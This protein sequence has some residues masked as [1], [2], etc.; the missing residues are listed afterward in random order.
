MTQKT[1]PAAPAGTSGND[2]FFF[3]TF[4]VA[5]A[6]LIFL[7]G[8]VL[9]AEGIP[10]G[11]QI[12]R[13]LEGGKA[14]YSKLTFHDDVFMSDL[15]HAPR[16]DSRGVT[17]DIPGKTSPGATL[18]TSGHEAAAFLISMDGEVLHKWQRPFS[19]IWNDTAAVRE[20]QPDTHVY[21]RKAHIF[22][23]GDLLATYE[24]AGDTPYGY[25]LVKLDWDSN[26]IWSY[27]Q[28][29]HHD[30]DVAPDGRI[31]LLTQEIV[32]TPIPQ[33]E[34]LHTPRLEDY[35]VILSPEGKELRKI[36][37][38][39]VV[40]KSLYRQILW[41]ISS[42]ALEDSLH[43]N[44]LHVITADDANFAFGK[45]G[46]VLIS[47]REPSTIGVIDVDE[48]KLVWA[49]KGYWSGQHDPH[50]LP[51]GDILV[52]DNKGNFNFPEGR[53]RALEFNP[54]TMAI[55]WQYRGTPDAPLESDIRSY[56]EREPN[57]NTLITE[58]NNGRIIEVTREGEI[59][60]EYINPVR[61][62]P[63]GKIPIICKAQ[64]VKPDL[65]AALLAQ[66]GGRGAAGRS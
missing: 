24:G 57:G 13:A 34:H 28:P 63:D 35:L 42:F 55:V 43:T 37:L 4:I 51:N 33:L 66:H 7:A 6:A 11:P 53:S 58:S 21:M 19:R 27:L 8:A 50:I 31:Y 49:V 52:F 46:Q 9:T 18:Y 29:A 44:S 26:V 45:P 48:E 62:G 61:D 30:F 3:I 23:N 39:D 41:G 65:T 25:G 47:F 5:I 64:R 15:W 56:T 32:D 36:A 14:F 54:A 2:R 1:A 38:L 60:W 17:I 59:V 22:D 10:P 40:E 20:P 16:T 12:S